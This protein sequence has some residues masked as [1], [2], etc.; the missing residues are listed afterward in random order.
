M[1]TE[2]RVESCTAVCPFYLYEQ[3]K[4]RS[5]I[6]CEGAYGSSTLIA[7][8]TRRDKVV[9]K[10]RYCD[11]ETGCVRCKMYRLAMTKYEEATR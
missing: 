2:P 3:N 11:S 1:S 4:P 5:T 10:A 8:E 9:H 7:F 6:A